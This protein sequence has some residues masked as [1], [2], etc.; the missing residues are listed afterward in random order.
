LGSNKSSATASIRLSKYYL[1][2]NSTSSNRIRF[3]SSSSPQSS[4]TSSTA[5][6]KTTANENATASSSSIR[7]N[8]Y[9]D[10]VVC[11][12]GMVGTAMAYALSREELF[13]NLRIALIESSG[14]KGAYKCSP[15][16]NNRVCALGEK[17]INFFKGIFNSKQQHF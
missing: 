1:I 12:G 16:H 17:T 10:V 7:A 15:I 2:N 8:D 14:A 9:F 4:T 13:K 6:N 3:Y 5:D 11:G